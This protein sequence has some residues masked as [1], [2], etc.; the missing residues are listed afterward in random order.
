MLSNPNGHSAAPLWQASRMMCARCHAVIAMSR[1][2]VAS[3][4]RCRE[5]CHLPD[6]LLHQWQEETGRYL[7]WLREPLEV[8]PID[9]RDIAREVDMLCCADWEKIYAW[10][11]IPIDRPKGLVIGRVRA[12]MQKWQVVQLAWSLPAKHCLTFDL[13]D[14]QAKSCLCCTSCLPPNAKL[15]GFLLQDCAGPFS[16]NSGDVFS[17]TSLCSNVIRTL[18]RAIEVIGNRT[19]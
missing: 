4:A 14:V 1:I 6:A 5:T 17:Y 15:K 3:K 10:L 13:I 9:M 7:K 19:S 11:D 2:G 16:L 8:H 12:I 18:Q